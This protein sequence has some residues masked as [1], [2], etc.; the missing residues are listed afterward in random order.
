MRNRAKVAAQLFF[1][2]ACGDSNMPN[3]PISAQELAL[4]QAFPNLVFSSPVFLTDS[5]DGSNRL[6][7][8]EQQ[9]LIRVFQNIAAVNSAE[10]FLDIR[11]RVASGGERGLLGLAFHPDFASNGFLYVNYTS[12]IGGPLRTVVSRFSA[13]GNSADPGSEI[14]LLEIQQPFTNHNGGMLA[15][16]ADGFLYV[17]VGDGGSGGDPSN[18]AQNRTVLLGK[19]LRIDVD[20][21]DPGLRYAI[22]SSN[23]FAG[24]GGGIRGEIFAYG[25]RNPW[26]FSIDSQTGQIWCGDVG[27]QDFEEVNLIESGKNYGWRVMEGF[28]CFNPQSGC[29]QTGLTLPVVEYSHNGGNC[30]VTGGYIYRGASRPELT[31]AFIYG[32]F[33]SGNI[34][35]LRYDGQVRADSLLLD[36]D[37]SISSF[38]KDEQGELYIVDIAGRIFRFSESIATSIANPDGGNVTKLFALSQ[39]HPNPFNPATIIA[40]TVEQAGNGELSIF[41]TL[42]QRIRTLFRGRL[43][44]GSYEAT[45]DGTNETGAVVAAGTYIYQLKMHSTV[46]TGRMTLVR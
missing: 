35:L 40:Y 23:P 1:V 8:V 25:L 21:Q 26:R 10:T 3:G 4:V 43:T 19:I 2:L 29:N 38:G 5:N 9:G 42:G 31:G 6:F 30:S 28:H 27:Q 44:P 17:A 12:S 32:D 34:W 18:N 11:G 7:V 15:F 46:R 22:P 13:N 37:L 24:A 41:N 45:W 39:N 16:D 20:R 33:C 36:T 14:I